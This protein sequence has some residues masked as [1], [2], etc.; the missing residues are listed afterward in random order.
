MM[1]GYILRR[2]KKKTFCL[3]F[4]ERHPAYTRIA[5]IYS[6]ENGFFQWVTRASAVILIK[7]MKFVSKDWERMFDDVVERL[8]R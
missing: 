3:H 2:E 6:S 4:P 8:E 7:N 5:I 1:F